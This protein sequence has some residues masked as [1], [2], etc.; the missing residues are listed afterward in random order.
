MTGVWAICTLEVGLDC[1]EMVLPDVPIEGVICLSERTPEDSISGY[2]Y[3]RPWCEDR[4]LQVVEVRS[5]N[6]SDPE[7]RAR[8]E[9]LDIGVLLV[10]GWQRLIPGWLISHTRYGVIGSHGSADGIQGGRGRSPQNWALL[11]GAPGFA[12]SIFRIDSGV[13]SGA[14][15][16]TRSFSYVASD[17]IASSYAKATW[18]VAAMIRSGW[19]DGSLLHDP[20]EPQKGEARY[21][22]QRRPEDG[23]IDW[24]RTPDAVVRFVRAVTRPY[25]GAF[26]VVPGGSI[27]IWAARQFDVGE[28]SVP[29]APGE[30]VHRWT[31]G[32]LLVRC[33]NGLLLI[34]D[35]SMAGAA[36]PRVG[37]ILPS[38]SFKEQMASIITRHEARYPDLPI[39]PV[40]RTA[41]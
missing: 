8:L 13:D 6:L 33:G 16:A 22:P 41:T 35:F 10:M 29:G 37:D 40:L 20:G 39:S 14:V 23:E 19:H 25:P 15:L 11:L 9:A 27:R 36:D 34:D 1:L 38:A 24:H 26:S 31:D 17:D 7:D 5:Y 32:R 12:I 21:L 2:A 3:A 30:V 4:G 28:P 18:L